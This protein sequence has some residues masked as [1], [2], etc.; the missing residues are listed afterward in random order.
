MQPPFDLNLMST[1]R[2]DHRGLTAK[3]EVA[4]QL[5]QS[6]AKTKSQFLKWQIFRTIWK[7]LKEHAVGGPLNSPN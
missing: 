5:K 2:R 1:E 4:R 7:S 3:V 6:R